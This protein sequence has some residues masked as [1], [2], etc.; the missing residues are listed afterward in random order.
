[1]GHGGN[2]AM[3][4]RHYNRPGITQ[5]QGRAFFGVKAAKAVKA[6]EAANG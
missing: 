2:P 3:L 6:K 5:Q 1:M 4:F